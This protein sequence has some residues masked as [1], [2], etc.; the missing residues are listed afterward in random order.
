MSIISDALKKA[1][2]ERTY[3]DNDPIETEMVSQ[4]EPV[5]RNIQDGGTGFR[6]PLLFLL[7]VSVFITAGSFL[8]LYRAQNIRPAFDPVPA[9]RE[10]ATDP[11]YSAPADNT[12]GD[13]DVSGN[14]S[15][16]GIMYSSDSPMAVINGILVSKGD[17]V[18][19]Y[20]V[21]DISPQG[22]KLISSDGSEVA[23]EL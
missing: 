3:V 13:T 20:R 2:K 1:Q 7:A 10:P 8:A 22:V 9:P 18:G 12:G 21:S 19:G 5:F 4:A 11:L 15:L 14:P 17:P 23:L 6:K 16:S